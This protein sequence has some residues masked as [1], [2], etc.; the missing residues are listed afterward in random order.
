MSKVP[1]EETTRVPRGSEQGHW[2]HCQGRLFWGRDVQMA[3]WRWWCWVR[4]G[5][6]VF[7]TEWTRP[8]R[9]WGELRPRGHT[10]Q[11]FEGTDEVQWVGAGEWYVMGEKRQKVQRKNRD[12]ACTLGEAPR[13]Y[14]V[15]SLPIR[16]PFYNG[17]WRKTKEE[18]PFPLWFSS[19]MSS[20]PLETSF[21]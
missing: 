7:Q 21:P 9:Q 2:P 3:T 17:R 1:P 20:N 6:W 15:G 14:F 8:P 10:V 5:R 4:G 11:L 18:T 16:L 12:N 19:P 13:D